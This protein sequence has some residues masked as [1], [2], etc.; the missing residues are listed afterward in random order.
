MV[1]LVSVGWRS[2][3]FLL[4]LGFGV[5]ARLWLVGVVLVICGCFALLCVC[6]VIG[7]LFWCLCLRVLVGV[8]S[9]DLSGS[10]LS[11]IICLVGFL[12]LWVCLACWFVVVFVC[13]GGCVSCA[14]RSSIAFGL[15]VFGCWWVS[16]WLVVVFIVVGSF[17]L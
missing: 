4:S 9:V 6:C 10:L 12:R 7:S 3:C 17:V 8:N 16:D 1:L 13:D 15:V 5:G 11:C 2:W 14:L